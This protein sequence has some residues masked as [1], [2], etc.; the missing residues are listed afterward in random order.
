MA[1]PSSQSFALPSTRAFL[2]GE[3]CPAK[4]QRSRAQ[5][6]YPDQGT[7]FALRAS[8][9]AAIL[10][11]GSRS[12]RDARLPWAK[13]AL[14]S[15]SAAGVVNRRSTRLRR[16]LPPKVG[17]FTSWNG[18]PEGQ[19]IPSLSGHALGLPAPKHVPSTPSLLRMH[20][21]PQAEDH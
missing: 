9:G 3:G 10:T 18:S 5:G 17:L 4:L 11:D 20:A 14:Q 13:D 19:A 15:F 12:F 6:R 21:G 1:R 7:S 8:D 16:A 2:P